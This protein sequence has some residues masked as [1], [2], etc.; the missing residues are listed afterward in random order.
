[1]KRQL[2]ECRMG[3]ARATIETR[4]H[5]GAGFHGVR[6]AGRSL[7]CATWWQLEQ[8]ELETLTLT[9]RRRARLDGVTFG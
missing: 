7:A 9:S 2:P 6:S 5:Q 8:I 4:V 3:F 1:M